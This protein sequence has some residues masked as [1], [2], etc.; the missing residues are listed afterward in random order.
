MS[1]CTLCA[2]LGTFDAVLRNF[3]VAISTMENDEER[4]LVLCVRAAAAAQ[5][6]KKTVAEAFY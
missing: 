4:L 1:F 2:P 3:V 5:R 6:S